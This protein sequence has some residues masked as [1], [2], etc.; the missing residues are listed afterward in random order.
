MSSSPTMKADPRHVEE[1]S[2]ATEVVTKL[3]L[4]PL[5]I[6]QAGAFIS[7]RQISFRRYLPLLSGGLKASTT[8]ASDWQWGQQTVSILTTWEIS[9][10]SLS[11]SAQELLL[12]CGFLSNED[13]PEELFSLNSRVRFDWM[14][15]GKAVFSVY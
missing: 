6:T 14:G 4:L 8:T 12:L 2:A 15:E 9:F 11:R 13:I 5:A 7:R 3:G 10:A 1:C